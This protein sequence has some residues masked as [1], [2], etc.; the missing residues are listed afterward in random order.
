MLMTPKAETGVRPAATSPEG[1]EREGARTCKEHAG[2]ECGPWRITGV[3]VW[4][5]IQQRVRPYPLR[6][7]VRPRTELGILDAPSWRSF[8]RM[9]S[10]WLLNWT[11]H[12][13]DRQL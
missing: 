7:R 3:R 4:S 10:S 2:K 8:R 5:T 9:Y 13:A 11:C 6:I 1:V 12:S